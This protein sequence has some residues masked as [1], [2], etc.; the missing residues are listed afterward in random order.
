[1]LGQ[2]LGQL[3]V[4]LTLLRLA[5]DPLPG[6]QV[7]PRQALSGAHSRSHAAMAVAAGVAAGT[8]GGQPSREH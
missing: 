5:A 7:K 1:M 8:L 3:G 2:L 4:Y 6:Y